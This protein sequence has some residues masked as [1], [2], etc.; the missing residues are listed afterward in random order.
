MKNVFVFYDQRDIL[1]LRWIYES[2]EYLGY[3]VF[4]L[5]W[6]WEPNIIREK[7]RELEKGSI[8]IFI[9]P[10]GTTEINRRS[11]ILE[12]SEALDRIFL[13]SQRN[14]KLI[15]ISLTKERLVGFFQSTR[16]TSIQGFSE[17]S[18]RSVIYRLLNDGSDIDIL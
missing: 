8:I 15:S 5:T 17:F 6:E 13:E 2:I 12:Y 10:L 7:V 9:Y 1:W 14:Y 3:R 18:V 16:N 4:P 11:Q